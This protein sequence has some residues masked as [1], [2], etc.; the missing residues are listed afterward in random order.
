MTI[1]KLVAHRGQA[2]QY[3]ENTLP[4]IESALKAGACYVEVD[5][6]LTA[7]GVP[8][9]FHDDDMQRI[10]GHAQNITQLNADQL[11][12]Y[13]ACETA[14]FGEKFS[15]TPIPTLAELLTLL[16]AWPDRQAF[17]EIKDESTKRFGTDF[18]VKKIMSQLTPLGTQCIPIS[19]EVAAL[20]SARALGANNIGWVAAKWDDASH[21]IAKQLAPNY[22]FTNHTRLPENPDDIWR[23]PWQWALYEVT[24]PELA[25][26]LAIK[27][28][29][30]IET[31]AI[32]EMLSHP[33]LNQNRCGK[34]S[35]G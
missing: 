6:Q 31:M 11:H 10:S 12:Q 29:D 15:D 25:L 27:G 13:S 14:R 18:V 19:Y 24:D 2:S 33:T 34:N 5:I 3:P 22:L 16:R 23:G 17:I 8:V 30:L 28:I 9:L 21:Q 1:P 20:E 4:A 35:D 7:D 26:T 32:E